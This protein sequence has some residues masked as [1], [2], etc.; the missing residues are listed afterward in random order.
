MQQRQRACRLRIEEAFVQAEAH[1]NVTIPRVRITFSNSQKTTAGTA[2]YYRDSHFTPY[3]GTEIRLSNT[4]LRLNSEEFVERTPGHE[5]AHI[6]AVHLFQEIGH[7][8]K[9]KE[10]MGV[11]GQPAL[12][13]HDM[14]VVRKK[15]KKYKYV[16]TTGYEIEISA[17]RHSKIQKRGVVYLVRGEGKLNKDGFVGHSYP[18]RAMAASAAPKRT[19]NVPKKKEASA[20][21]QGP[22][23]KEKATKMCKALKDLGMS[24]DAVVSNDKAVSKFALE[25]GTTASQARKYIKGH[26]PR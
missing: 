19:P 1:Y 21:V 15:V 17:Q 5:A 20:P 13:T 18:A 4:V 3:R 8:P 9:W 25:L 6:I 7:G 10:V 26:W 2:H 24:Y 16:T 12:R 23:K 11:I 22:S 14:Q